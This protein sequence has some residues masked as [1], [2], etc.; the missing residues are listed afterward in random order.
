MKTTTELIRKINEV[1]NKGYD[2]KMTAKI[3][4]CSKTI[5]QNYV[6]EARP[7]STRFE[8]LEVDKNGNK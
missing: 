8:L 3:L 1:Y 6:K 5:V 2:M 4:G 7:R